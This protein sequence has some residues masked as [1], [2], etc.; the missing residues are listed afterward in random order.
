MK[1]T[2]AILLLAI[3]SGAEAWAQSIN[4]VPPVPNNTPPSDVIVSDSEMILGPQMVYGPT[5]ELLPYA[6]QPVAGGYY[7]VPGQQAM[8]PAQAPPEAPAAVAPSRLSVSIDSLWLDRNFNSHEVLGQTVSIPSGATVGTL[9]PAGNVMRPGVRLQSSYRL[10]DELVLEGIYFGLQDWTSNYG[11]T[12]D[13]FAGVVAYSPY[14]QS[15]KLIGG[16]GTGLNYSYSSR[17]N[18]AEINLRAPV[19]NI[20]RWT[21]DNLLGLRF[22]ELSESFNLNGQDA[23]F[24]V[25]ENLNTHTSN[26]LVGPQIGTGLRRQCDANWEIGTMAKAALCGNFVSERFSNLNSTGV[27]TGFPPGFVPISRGKV[28]TEVAGVLDF[29]VI[30][31]YRVN[32]Y[33]ALR[34]G[35]QVL[36]LAGVALASQQLGGYSRGGDVFLHG[37]SAGLEFSH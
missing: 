23:F 32:Q 17:L 10:N 34:G 25:T 11:L 29:S 20:G 5:A 4:P 18:N 1:R 19:A 9:T 16:F 35:Y 37:P 2:A 31:R 13:L 8:M 30:G 15:D 27:T 24:G 36:Y 22:V 3:A 12:S 33:F 7:V 26:S 28:A 21:R 14:T 6:G